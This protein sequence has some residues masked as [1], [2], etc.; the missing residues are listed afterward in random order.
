MHRLS[1]CEQK[2]RSLL[3]QV[4]YDTTRFLFIPSHLKIYAYVLFLSLGKN[5]VRCLWFIKQVYF[6]CF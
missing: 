2:N 1:S 4:I 5:K 3:I 6:T